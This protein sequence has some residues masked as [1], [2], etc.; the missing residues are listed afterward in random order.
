MHRFWARG[1]GLLCAILLVLHPLTAEACGVLGVYFS[2]VLI[3]PESGSAVVPLNVEPIIAPSRMGVSAVTLCAVDD[4]GKATQVPSTIRQ[5]PAGMFRLAPANLLKPETLH[6]LSTATDCS[7][8]PVGQFTTGTKEDTTPPEFD[9]VSAVIE[10]S[11][12]AT[13]ETRCGV[14]DHAFYRLELRAPVDAEG[15]TKNLVLL[16]Y[17]G[18]SAQTVDFEFPSMI[19]ESEHRALTGKLSPDVRDNLAVVVTALDW[20]G[21][22]SAQQEPVMAQNRACGCHGGGI[23]G[24]ALLGL[25]LVPSLLRPRTRAG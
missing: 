11:F 24:L 15:G 19:L 5:L 12:K 23:G 9:G 2:H 13:P 25:L 4:K 7:G 16:V 10:D 1:C 17:D 18:P 21:N 6:V 14:V 3:I 20:A 22:E 8:D